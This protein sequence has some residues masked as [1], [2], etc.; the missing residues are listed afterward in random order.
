[1]EGGCPGRMHRYQENNEALRR[2]M[3]AI[4]FEEYLA[5][6]DQG[7]IIN[8]YLYPDHPAFDFA[9]FYNL[10]RDDGFVIYPGKVGDADV[11]R[12]GNIGHIRTPDI[13]ALT[14]AM[15]RAL[16]TMGVETTPA[17]ILA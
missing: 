15:R 1:M 3:R 4:G 2:E 14:G 12:V 10:L 7:W 8:S 5:E 16:A 11:F 13:L 6:P 9:T 17:A